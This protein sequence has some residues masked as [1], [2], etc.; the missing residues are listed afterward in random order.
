MSA[1][2]RDLVFTVLYVSLAIMSL[3]KFAK[4]HAISSQKGITGQHLNLLNIL[5]S[6]LA[7]TPPATKDSNFA[8]TSDDISAVEESK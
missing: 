5:S 1:F 2:Q 6:E 4:P 8:V 3:N 7:A